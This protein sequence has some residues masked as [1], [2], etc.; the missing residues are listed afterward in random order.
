M[1]S[2]LGGWRSNLDENHKTTT[3][4]SNRER[5]NENHKKTIKKNHQ[6]IS[7]SRNFYERGSVADELE[8]GTPT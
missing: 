6:G 1:R 3:E 5:V 8:F 4:E 2:K 7:P